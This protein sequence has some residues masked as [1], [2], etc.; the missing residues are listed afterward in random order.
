MSSDVADRAQRPDF[1]THFLRGVERFNNLEFWEA[2][3]EWEE[4]WLHASSEVHQFLQGL[5]QIAAAYHHVKRGTLRGAVRLFDAALARLA[6]FPPHYCSVDRLPLVEI[7]LRHRQ[8]VAD[9]LEGSPGGQTSWTERVAE[10]NYPVIR[11]IEASSFP[12]PPSHEW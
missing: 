5:I 3:E 9:I 8:L 11:M 4:I 2:H 1:A 12:M 6:V 10:G 7:C